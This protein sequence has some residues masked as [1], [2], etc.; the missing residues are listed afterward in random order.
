MGIYRK[1]WGVGI[2][3]KT[4]DKGTQ[5]KKLA[6]SP[7]TRAQAEKAIEV[8]AKKAGETLVLMNLESE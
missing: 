7:M 8:A 3:F 5:V 1:Q 2:V 6:L 4:E